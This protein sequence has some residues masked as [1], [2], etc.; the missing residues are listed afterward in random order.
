MKIQYYNF[1]H[2]ATGILETINENVIK[3]ENFKEDLQNTKKY[4][5]NK[6]L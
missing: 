2:T 5:R 3:S 1:I 6:L 4:V